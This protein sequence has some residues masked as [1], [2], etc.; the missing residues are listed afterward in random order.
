MKAQAYYFK[1]KFV[2]ISWV[3]EFSDNKS[4]R[5]DDIKTLTIEPDRIIYFS[6]SLSRKSA[7]KKIMKFCERRYS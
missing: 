5:A 7:F 3:L 4:V 6:L 1:W 2:W